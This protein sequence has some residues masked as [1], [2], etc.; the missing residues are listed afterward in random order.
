MYGLSCAAEMCSQPDLR[1]PMTETRNGSFGHNYRLIRGVQVDIEVDVV[2]PRSCNWWCS[3]ADAES[4]LGGPQHLLGFLNMLTQ[5]GHM[6][7][8]S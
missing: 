1:S 8:H 2:G 7:E 3:T 4:I 5:V 6:D